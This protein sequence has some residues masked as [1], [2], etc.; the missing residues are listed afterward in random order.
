MPTIWHPTDF[1]VSWG[2]HAANNLAACP[3]NARTSGE[4]R[5]ELR[6]E[7]GKV[8]ISGCQQFGIPPTL[9]EELRDEPGKVGVLGCQQFGIPPTLREELR[10]EPGKVGVLGCQQFGI[11]PTLRQRLWRWPESR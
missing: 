9:R 2:S 6:D 7:P 4:G 11:P 8:G 10:D 3:A 5:E 1:T